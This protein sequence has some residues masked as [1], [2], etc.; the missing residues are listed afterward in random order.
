LKTIKSIHHFIILSLLAAMLFTSGVAS[1]D[2][3]IVAIGDA[4]TVALPVAAATLDS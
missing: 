4:L 1:A 3:A 2:D